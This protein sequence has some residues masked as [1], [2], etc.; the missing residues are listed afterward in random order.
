MSVETG[1]ELA[2]ELHTSPNMCTYYYGFNTQADV[3][4]DVRVRRALSLAVNRQELIDQVLGGNP[5]PARWFSR[6]GLVAA[7]TLEAYPDLGVGY[8]PV[9]AYALLQDYLTDVGMTARRIGDRVVV[10]CQCRT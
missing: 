9:Q 6:P 7:P 5:E 8:D 3:V 2:G 1:P 10:Q 4:N